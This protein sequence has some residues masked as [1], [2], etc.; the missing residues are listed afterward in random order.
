MDLL[1]ATGTVYEEYGYALTGSKGN[2]DPYVYPGA[3]RAVRG[4]L[5]ISL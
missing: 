3:L 5:T 1:N 4:G 2:I